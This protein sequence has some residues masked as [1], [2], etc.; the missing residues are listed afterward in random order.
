MAATQASQQSN[1]PK[2]SAF[3][4]DDLF[5]ASGAKKTNGT[6][7]GSGANSMASLAQQKQSSSLWGSNA[8]SNGGGAGQGGNGDLLF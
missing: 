1:K 3:D 7:S 4:F 8:G 5:A 2:A 6:S